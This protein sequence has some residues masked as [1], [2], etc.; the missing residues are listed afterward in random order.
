MR[1]VLDVNAAIAPCAEA[2][3]LCDEIQGSARRIVQL[4][5]AGNRP[6]IANEAGKLSFRANAYRERFRAMAGA[7]EGGSDAA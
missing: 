7:I 6:A 5:L 3:A 1:V 4:V 2:V